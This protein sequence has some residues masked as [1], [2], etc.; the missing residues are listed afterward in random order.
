MRRTAASGRGVGRRGAARRLR[1]W[2]P[3]RRRRHEA[4]RRQDRAGRAQRPVRRLRRRCP[5]RTRS[6][7]VR[8]GDRRL[9]GQVRRQG[10]DQEHHR[11]D[12]PTTRT[13]RTSP[14]PRPQE[15]YDRKGVD[16]ILDVPTSSAALAVADVAK[17]EEEAVLQHRRG[18]HRPDRQELQQVH[19]PLRVRHLHA[20]Q[21]HR[22]DGHRAGRARTGTS[23]T[24]TT[25]SGRTWSKSFTAAIERR[26]R[27]GRRQATRRRSR[28]DN[29]STLPAQ[30]ADAEP[31]AGRARHHAGR[32]RPGQR[33]E[34]V[35]RVQAAR[36]RAS[37]WRS[38]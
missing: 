19:L 13:S 38:G 36:T 9:Q 8:D 17:A 28:T 6:K 12:A 18:H 33:G 25:R 16:A 34:A 22:Q 31:E 29:F 27:H 32:R 23:S 26:R 30:G 3:E 15:M 10:G 21:R 2:R 24:R 5:A 14:T 4:D 20:G 37:A 35:Q 7:A 11:G 1:R